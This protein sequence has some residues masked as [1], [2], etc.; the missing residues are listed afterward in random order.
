M[1]QSILHFIEKDIKKI[2]EVAKSLLSGEKDVDHLSQEIHDCVMNLACSLNGEIYEKIDEE[3]RNSLV[4]KKKWVVEQRNEPKSIL[5]I[6]GVVKFN[7]TGYKNKNTGEYVYLL[8]KVLRFD[9]HQR[10]SL[11]AAARILEE[12]VQSNYRKGGKSASPYDAASKQ[13]VKRLVHNTVIDFPLKEPAK[14]KE[15]NTLYIVADEDHVSAQF[16]NKKGDL[17]KDSRGNTINTLMPKLV[18]VYE[19]IE[20]ES[21]EKSKNPRYRLIGKHYFSGIYKGESENIR[22]WDEVRDYIHTVYDVSSLERIYIIGDGA[23]W[24][25]SGVEVLEN[26][27]FVLDKYHMMKYINASVSHLLDHAEEVKGE[28]WECINGNHKKRLQE[29]YGKIFSVTEEGSKYDEVTRAFNYL[30]NNWSGISIRKRESARLRCCAEGQ[31]SHVLSA[32]LSSRPMGWSELGC[33]QMAKL[34]AY[35]W[36]GGKVIDLLRYQ[37]QKKELEESREEQAELTKELR[38]RQS[39]WDYAEQMQAL[40][41]GLGRRE[42]HWMRD[43]INRQLGA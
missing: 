6:C 37:K 2:E 16:W 26:S 19:G 22:L 32:R 31:V 43:I 20:N 11:G 15:P 38:R 9:A 25:K 27:R 14:K 4:R 36:N 40:I 35:H 30:L 28:I 29:I 13:A 23:A 39:G 7:R 10:I 33:D 8:D 1:Y 17:A 18:C 3:I 42:M 21:G 5:D 24:I 41:P 34:R 12:T